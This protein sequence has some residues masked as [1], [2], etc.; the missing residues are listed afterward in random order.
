MSSSYT[1][2]GY[3]SPD[4]TVT[5]ILNGYTIAKKK[6]NTLLIELLHAFCFRDEKVKNMCKEPVN[7]VVVVW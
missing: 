3:Y 2:N 4:T 1:V 6:K 7:I 5:G